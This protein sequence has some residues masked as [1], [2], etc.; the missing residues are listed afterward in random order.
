MSCCTDRVM[1]GIETRQLTHDAG[2]LLVEL[3]GNRGRTGINRNLTNFTV[4]RTAQQSRA[5][6]DLGRS[7]GLRAALPQVSAL[8]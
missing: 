1:N 5:A 6:A 3:L 8:E 4:Q 7:D 2:L